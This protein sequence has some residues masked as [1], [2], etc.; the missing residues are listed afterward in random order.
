MREVQRA[1]CHLHLRSTHRPVVGA[2]SGARPR[3]RSHE[4]VAVENS[5]PVEAWNFAASPD[6][7]AQWATTAIASSEYNAS[8]GGHAGDRRAQSDAVAAISPAP[9][10][11]S[12]AAPARN[13]CA[14][15]TPRLSTPP[16]CASTRPTSAAFVTGLDLVEPNGTVHTLSIAID[17]TRLSRLFRTELHPDALSRLRGHHPHPDSR[18]GRDRCRGVIGLGGA[19]RQR[20]RQR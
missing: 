6:A 10:R 16:A 20:R 12:P 9:G 8:Y 1:V 15:V 4:A 5:G 13:G 17:N 14:W 19:G 18:L 2:R 3:R 7:L 11:L